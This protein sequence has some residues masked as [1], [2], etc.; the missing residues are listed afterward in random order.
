MQDEHNFHLDILRGLAVLHDSAFITDVR[1]TAEKFPDPYLGYALNR[2]QMTS[3]KWLVDKLYSVTKGNVGHVCVLGGWYG[4]LGALLLHDPRFNVSKV[5]SVDID[6][7]C[8][9]VALSLNDTH[10]K[11]DQFEF[12]NADMFNLDYARYGFDLVINTSCEHVENLPNW[13]KLIPNGT[14]LTL[15]S[16]NYFGI[17]GH[18]NCVHDLEEFKSQVPIVS[19][20]YEGALELKKYTRFMVIGRR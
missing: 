6:S 5:T 3:K 7:R 19:V 9:E 2:N 10:V 12:M 16:N 14:F 11:K 18:I 17:E 13:F 4:V 15:Q 1:K 8:E 20:D